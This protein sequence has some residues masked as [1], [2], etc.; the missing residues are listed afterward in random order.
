MGEP[1]VETGRCGAVD[2]AV[3]GAA[4]PGQMRSGDAFLVQETEAGVLVGVV[5]G[6][7][8]GEEAADVAERAL[9]SVRMTAGQSLIGSLTACHVALRGSRGV[10]MT[11]A[12]LDTHRAQLT[13]VAV[14]NVDAAV[15]RRRSAGQPAKRFSVPLRAGV[16]GDRLP[17][18]REATVAMSAGDTLV[19]ATDGISPAF[20]D[21]VDLSLDGRAL[22]CTLHRRYSR[23]DDDALVLV[24]R[25]SRRPRAD[26]GAHG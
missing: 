10:V 1:V 19:A 11:L 8:H 17:P 15:L 6:L 20:L 18:L 9:E 13:W 5:D 14:G 2:W 22:A 7:G 26:G 21:E 25:P 4:Y 24:A 12:M 16:L 23:N 3:C